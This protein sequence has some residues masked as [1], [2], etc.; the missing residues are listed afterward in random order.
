MQQTPQSTARLFFA[1]W[2][3]D[4]VR[5]GLYKASRPAVDA[6]DG[7]PVTAANLHMTLVFLGSVDPE[8]EARAHGAAAS[9][10]GEPFSLELDSFGHWP[11]PQV[12]WCGASKVPDA[13]RAL[14]A[15]LRER[16]VSAGLKPDT[17]NFV[18]HV[19][20]VRKVRWPGALGSFGP[21]SWA[22][23]DFTLVR[24]VT[25]RNG[26]E[27]SPLATYA[28]DAGGNVK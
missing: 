11:E 18:P 15:R 19:T 7:K 21:L 4:G 8:G 5:E 14:T 10:H 3:T 13:A 20:L 6:A 22:A 27:Y 28:L 26:S 9:V 2:P 23:K 16:L 17:K 25:G 24:S 1:L 12:L